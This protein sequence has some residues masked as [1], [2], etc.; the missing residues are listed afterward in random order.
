MLL[1]LL[2]LISCWVV[3]ASL[4]AEQTN[5]G[6]AVFVA[7]AASMCGFCRMELLPSVLRARLSAAEVLS[8][9]SP[10][11]RRCFRVLMHF[12]RSATRPSQR[13]LIPG[14]SVDVDSLQYLLR[15]HIYIAGEGDQWFSSPMPAHRRGYLVG[16]DH[17]P[18]GGHDP[19]IAVCVF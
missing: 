19:T 15:R 5:A 10:V 14:H 12:V 6:V 3:A 2:L 11:L 17:P 16:F 4:V 9:A 13:G 7:D 8:L 1:F 18:Y